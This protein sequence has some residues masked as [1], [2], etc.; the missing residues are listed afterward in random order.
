MI[1]NIRSIQ[2][3]RMNFNDSLGYINNIENKN[4]EIIVL[5]EKFITETIDKEK[6]KDLI[7]N[8]KIDNTIVLGSLSYMDKY[9][10]NRSFLINNRKIIGFQDKINLYN[11]EKLRYKSGDKIKMFN[12]N[13]IKLGI[14]IC[15]DLDF[16]EYPRKL[17]NNKCDVI[18]NPSLI[19]NKFHDEWHLYVE[20]RSLENRIPV[21]SVNSISDN[22]KGDS[23]TSIPYKYQN[24]VKLKNYT[25]KYNDICVSINKNDYIDQ[26]DLRINEEIPVDKIKFEEL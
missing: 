13:N 1:F 12:I 17:F 25:D 24:G 2:S 11:I 9:L 18:I 14:L 10:Y 6:L 8:I 4:N 22:F 23:I 16:P 7:D 5:P 20:L 19:N 3:K 21:I 15:Y 26:R